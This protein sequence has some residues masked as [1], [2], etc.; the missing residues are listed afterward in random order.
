MR[1]VQL[2]IAA[3]LSVR[4]FVRYVQLLNGMFDVRSR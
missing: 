4:P 1:A 3:R 2:L